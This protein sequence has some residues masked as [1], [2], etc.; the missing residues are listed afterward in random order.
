MP[1]FKKDIPKFVSTV[2]NISTNITGISEEE[3]II[4][5]HQI[6]SAINCAQ[7]Q[8]TI[9]KEESTALKSLRANTD[10]MLVPA[11]KGNMT[12]IMNTTDYKRK[13]E[14]HL[15]DPDTY[16]A[17]DYDPSNEIRKE[18]NS[19]LKTLYD[20][21]LLVKE[22]FCIYS[23]TQVRLHSSI[24]SSKS[25][26]LDIPSDQLLPPRPIITIIYCLPDL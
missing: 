22:E 26:K 10:L 13:I 4:L 8:E 21:K 7:K 25:T 16:T 23:Q 20:M 18:V 9:S 6:S 24:V 3:R 5:K 12:V 2:E 15:D 14:D 11:D 1:N 17:L 19:Y